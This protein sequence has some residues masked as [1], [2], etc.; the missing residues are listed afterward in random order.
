MQ[1]NGFDT[2]GEER[3]KMI[4]LKKS[5]EMAHAREKV[6]ACLRHEAMGLQYSSELVERLVA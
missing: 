1:L 2:Q 6:E 4:D 5:V 3:E